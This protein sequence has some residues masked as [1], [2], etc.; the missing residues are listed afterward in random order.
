M[1]APQVLAFAGSSREESYNR[2]LLAN[3]VPLLEAEGVGCTLIE[4]R[5]YPLPIYDGDL[6]AARGVPDNAIELRALF[7]AH[8]G[9]LIAAP[10]YNSSVS[11]LLKNTIDWVSRPVPRE[12]GSLPFQ[13]KLAAL[14]SASPGGFGGLRG[15]AAL[16][17]V[18]VTLGVVV[19]PQQFCLAQAH[20]AFTDDGGLGDGQARERLQAVLRALARWLRA[21]G[22]P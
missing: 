4:L 7:K 3:A 18:L 14:L 12:P 6:E 20:A 1:A 11:P 15:L 8:R 9:L 22:G 16:R 19:L 2:R 5:D 10:E 21:S 17:P 13:D